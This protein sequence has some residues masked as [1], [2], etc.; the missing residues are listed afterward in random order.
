MAAIVNLLI[1]LQFS[2][3]LV[4]CEDKLDKPYHVDHFG[5]KI[6]WTDESQG[7]NA[8]LRDNFLRVQKRINLQLGMGPT[9][10]TKSGYEK[11]RIPQHLFET[12]QIQKTEGLI[13]PENCGFGI[14][15]QLSNC[16]KIMPDGLILSQENQFQVEFG[17]WRIVKKVIDYQLRSVVTKWSGIELGPNSIFSGYLKRYTNGAVLYE[18]LGKLPKSIFTVILNVSIKRKLKTLHSVG[19]RPP[20]LRTFR[21]DSVCLKNLNSFRL[22]NV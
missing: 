16:Q 15:H 3:I 13:T 11:M 17:S 9:R 20:L 21:I 14:Y 8:T 2:Q 19:L 22:I 1:F 12:I 18:H 5:V 6:D 4:H 7:W 10:F